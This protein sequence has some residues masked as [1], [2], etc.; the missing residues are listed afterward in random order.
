MERIL[1]V[2]YGYLKFTLSAMLASALIFSLTGLAIKS[3][4]VCLIVIILGVA[5]FFLGR[6]ELASR[7]KHIESRKTGNFTPFTHTANIQSDPNSL[8]GSLDNIQKTT[9]LPP[10]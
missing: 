1:K 8:P 9:P 4:R 10:K 3:P 6:G 2:S 5:A 7:R